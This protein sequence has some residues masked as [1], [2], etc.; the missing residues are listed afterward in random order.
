[1]EAGEANPTTAPI[2]AR[3]VTAPCDVGS[4]APE[5]HWPIVQWPGSCYGLMSLVSREE[6][7]LCTSLHG[8]PPL[9][10]QCTA[11]VIIARRNAGSA[12]RRASDLLQA[13]TQSRYPPTP[14][15][16]G[17]ASGETVGFTNAR[18]LQINAPPRTPH[19]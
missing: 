7:I 18:E 6:K 4:L 15:L 11:F 5:A 1:M 2:P 13:P 14:P 9:R 19:K 17:G 3:D 12:E 10:A 8:M 16:A